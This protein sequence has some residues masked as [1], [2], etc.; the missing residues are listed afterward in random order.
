[1]QGFCLH[2]LYSQLATQSRNIGLSISSMAIMDIEPPGILMLEPTPIP[3]AGQGYPDPMV[4]DQS[5]WINYS[6]SDRSSGSKRIDVNISAGTIPD[7]LVLKIEAGSYA[8]NG[9][10]I[11]GTTTGEKTLS[12]SSQTLI[13][14]IV[15]G[16][17][18]NGTGNGH[19][20]TYKLEV[21]QF[22]ELSVTSSASVTI[23]FTITDN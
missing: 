14:N 21:G 4:I 2:S 23:Q 1:M 22:E 20:L 11:L 13:D 10:G 17:T 9:D 15:R 19:L 5:K 18:G 7:G 6:C 3:E 16:Y 12:Y 8:G